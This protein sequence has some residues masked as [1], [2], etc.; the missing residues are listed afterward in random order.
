M[1]K[2]GLILLLTLTSMMAHAGSQETMESI[3]INQANR[4]NEQIQAVCSVFDSRSDARAVCLAKIAVVRDQLRLNYIVEYVS[5][6]EKQTFNK[7]VLTELVSTV[8]SYY[9]NIITRS[10]AN[11]INS[12]KDL[13]EF[14]TL[15]LDE[16]DAAILPMYNS[17]PLYRFN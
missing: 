17:T 3:L 1:K 5:D 14:E 12:V 13:N 7:R 11:K 16:L 9:P 15:M 2:L 8:Q 4:T 10:V 6:Y